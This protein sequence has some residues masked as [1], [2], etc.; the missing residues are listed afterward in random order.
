MNLF[1]LRCWPFGPNL[2]AAG[3]YSF[4]RKHMLVLWLFNLPARALR[5]NF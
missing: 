2:L 4:G 5:V 1:R 3:F